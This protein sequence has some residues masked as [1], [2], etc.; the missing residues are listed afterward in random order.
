MTV[1]VIGKKKGDQR[2]LVDHH[3]KRRRLKLKLSADLQ[4]DHKDSGS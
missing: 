4:Q 2:K 1:S 3:K